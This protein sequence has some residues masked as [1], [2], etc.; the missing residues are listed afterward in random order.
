MWLMVHG[1]CTS[2]GG[3]RSRY[4]RMDRGRRR[5]NRVLLFSIA[6]GL[7]ATQIE[8]LGGRVLFV[9]AT[10]DEFPIHTLQLFAFTLGKHLPDHTPDNLWDAASDGTTELF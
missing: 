10:S 6:I 9:C 1:V 8:R 3:R 7:A 5:S 2:I 4:V